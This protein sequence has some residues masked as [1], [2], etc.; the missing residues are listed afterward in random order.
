MKKILLL[1][2]ILLV[3]VWG[4]AHV[5]ESE[6]KAVH[7]AKD[8]YGNCYFYLIDKTGQPDR[9]GAL[10]IDKEVGK[11]PPVV[12]GRK[13]LSVELRKSLGAQDLIASGNLMSPLDCY[14]FYGSSWVTTA[15][16]T[17]V[18]HL[19]KCP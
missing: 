1:V 5:S 8:Q 10:V 13:F 17:K 16:R 12:E 11:C 3:L 14:V 18:W 7:Y 6:L 9:L 19:K 2:I 4:C 15:T